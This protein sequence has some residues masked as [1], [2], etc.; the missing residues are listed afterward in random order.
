MCLAA[1]IE[2][3][4]ETQEVRH[5][6]EGC[7]RFQTQQGGCEPREAEN[8]TAVCRSALTLAHLQRCI[9]ADTDSDLLYSARVCKHQWYVMC[10]TQEKMYLLIFKFEFFQII[11]STLK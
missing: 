2:M 7:G 10:I 1:A 11:I 9:S 5:K 6:I 3:E 8:P 4:V